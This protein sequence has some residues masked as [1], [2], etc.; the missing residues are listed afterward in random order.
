MAVGIYLLSPKPVSKIHHKI[1]FWKYW[2]VLKIRNRF[3]WVQILS[4]DVGGGGRVGGGN[5]EKDGR[6][7]W[8]KKKKS[9]MEGSGHLLWGK[10][11]QQKKV[12]WR[13]PDTYYCEQEFCKFVGA[14]EGSAHCGMK[15]SSRFSLSPNFSFVTVWYFHF[16]FHWVILSPNSAI[17]PSTF[18][19]L[20]HCF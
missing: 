4:E 9:A 14:M 19:A 3:R 16:H 1:R 6:M 13:D 8:S 15:R 17:S 2:N 10:T 7:L 20:C 12:W 18:E 5:M 11:L